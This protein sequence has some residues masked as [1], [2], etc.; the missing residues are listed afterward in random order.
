[1]S[2]L[3][4]RRTESAKQRRQWGQRHLLGN[5]FWVR[6][7]LGAAPSSAFVETEGNKKENLQTPSFVSIPVTLLGPKIII[8]I[9]TNFKRCT[10]KKNPKWETLPI[11]CGSDSKMEEQE[12][13]QEFPRSR[14]HAPG[15]R[16]RKRQERVF[17]NP[18]VLLW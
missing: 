8:N 18:P 11:E 3:G 14:A 16:L 5:H 10:E 2:S 9:K 15:R 1:M 4:F 7:W 13:K 12:R 17:W 6:V